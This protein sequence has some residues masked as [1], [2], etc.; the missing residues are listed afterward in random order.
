VVRWEVG[1]QCCGLGVE[2]GRG[3]WLESPL[4][5]TARCLLPELAAN[6]I[7][8]QSAKIYLKRSKKNKNKLVFL[9]FL[10]FLDLEDPT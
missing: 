4:V 10:F 7:P 5:T 1:V 6:C 2:G 3:H 8:A 9:F